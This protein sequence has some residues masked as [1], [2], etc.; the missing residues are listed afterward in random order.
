[1]KLALWWG[2][3]EVTLLK[4]KHDPSSPGGNIGDDLH[5][6]A[7]RNRILVMTRISKKCEM[8]CWKNQASDMNFV[9]ESFPILAVTK[10]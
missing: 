9:P 6:Q 5:F 10:S 7:M 2:M 8:S 4:G 1:M 3:V